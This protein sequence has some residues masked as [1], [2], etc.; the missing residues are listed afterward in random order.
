MKT[1][2]LVS[3]LVLMALT[4]GLAGCTAANTANT[5]KNSDEVA[6]MRQEARGYEKKDGNLDAGYLVDRTLNGGRDFNKPV[7][8]QPRGQP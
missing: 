6:R 1:H 3:I 8:D 2:F 7:F 4:A 5:E